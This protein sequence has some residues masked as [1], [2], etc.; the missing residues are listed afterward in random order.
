MNL[1]TLE[2]QSGRNN[3]EGTVQCM[4]RTLYSGKPQQAEQ[5]PSNSILQDPG[6]WMC[7]FAAVCASGHCV[8]DT[9]W[10]SSSRKLYGIT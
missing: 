2:A 8:I 1:I 3:P 7:K 9:C 10:G 6:S 4:S 5:V